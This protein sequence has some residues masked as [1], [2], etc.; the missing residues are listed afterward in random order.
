LEEDGEL[1]VGII[2][3]ARG[4]Y[5]KSVQ[6]KAEVCLVKGILRL[7]HFVDLQSFATRLV[8]NV[9]E[10]WRNSNEVVIVVLSA[11]AESY[12]NN[13]RSARKLPDSDLHFCGELWEDREDSERTRGGTLY[14]LGD[15]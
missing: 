2:G 3:E 12:F 7:D 11:S 6:I 13:T 14:S 15:N 5:V 8:A 1:I 9:K 4:L 10:A